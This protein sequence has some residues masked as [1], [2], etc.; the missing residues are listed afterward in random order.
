MTEHADEAAPAAR[1]LW[2][3]PWE[4]RRRGV[5]GINA[6]NLDYILPR[7]PRRLYP[8]VDDKSLTKRVCESRNIPVP[9]TYALIERYGD[10][11]RF[12]E[13]LGERSEFVVKPARGAEGR[14]VLVIVDRRDGRFVRSNGAEMAV[15]EMNYHL[16]TTWSGL[17]SLGGRPDKVIVERR[18]R[19]HP[20]FDGVAVGGTPDIRIIVLE[21]EPVMAMIRLPTRRSRGRANLFQGAVGAGVDLDTGRASGGVCLSRAVS[22]HPD[23]GVALDRV[24]IPRWPEMKA[25]AAR[26]SPALG[27]GYV[28]VDFALD[29]DAGP[30]VLEA[31]ARPGLSIQ[32]ANRL[33]LIPR[34][35][36]AW[37][38][39]RA[40]RSDQEDASDSASP[41]PRR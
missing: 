32:I 40:G 20:V 25:L 9:E 10:L 36:E 35:D 41:R 23:T 27:L 15:A 22:A 8:L 2:A 33:G 26:L 18:V 12:E 16:A 21:G 29:G 5:L 19:P 28:G 31:N 6:R 37:G 39:V 34:L 17:H 1:R 3:W 30:V 11:R 4:L 13:F 38:R 14:G 24:E 7:N